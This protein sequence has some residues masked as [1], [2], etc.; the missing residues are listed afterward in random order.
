MP[1][2]LECFLSKEYLIEMGWQNLILI[3][4][5]VSFRVILTALQHFNQIKVLKPSHFYLNTNSSSWR[6]CCFVFNQTIFFLREELGGSWKH[7][8]CLYASPLVLL[9]SCMGTEISLKEFFCCFLN[10]WNT[11]HQTNVLKILKFNYKSNQVFLCF[12]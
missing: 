10:R 9:C 4:Y 11:F 2:F 8:I 1:H 5:C 3:Y 6:D 7:L 12:E